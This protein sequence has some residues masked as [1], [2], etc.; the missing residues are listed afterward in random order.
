MHTGPGVRG[1]SPERGV[2]PRPRRKRHRHLLRQDNLVGD[3]VVS[4]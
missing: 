1:E 3:K 2:H 4:G